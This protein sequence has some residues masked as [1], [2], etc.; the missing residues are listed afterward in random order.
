VT[1][2]TY[3]AAVAIVTNHLFSLVG[4]MGTHSSQPL[5]RVEHSGFLHAFHSTGTVV[6]F[7]I[8]DNKL[9]VTHV[10]ERCVLHDDPVVGIVGW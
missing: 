7:R 5:Q 10:K 2:P 8:D 1:S 4:H 9:A 3:V 6:G